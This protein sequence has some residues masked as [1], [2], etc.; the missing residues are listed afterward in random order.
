MPL[1]KSK[2][3]VFVHGWASGPYVWLHQA[4]FFNN[5]CA[6]HTPQLEGDGA[7]IK[8]FIIKNN[9]ND[10][11]LIGWS[12]G[13]MVSLNLA[14]ELKDRIKSLVVIGTNARFTQSDDF[15]YGI[16]KQ[17]LEKIY[18]RMQNDFQGTLEW[19]YKFCFSS[20]ERSRNEYSHVIKLLGDFIAPVNSD[21]LLYG[22]KLL[23]DFDVR[24]ILAFISAP[25]LIIQ[26][27]QDRVCPVSAAGFLSREIKNSKTEIFNDAGHA[28]HLTEPDRVNR[29][30]EEF[31]A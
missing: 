10:V 12:L 15:D 25:T 17:V 29:L 20:N 3:I 26:G 23:M 31:I 14:S 19:F 1:E 7:N 8:D 2:N 4:S 30:I 6:V 27:G 22:L 28:P 16:S 9:L 18:K 11:C 13:G 21:E 24:N 5:K